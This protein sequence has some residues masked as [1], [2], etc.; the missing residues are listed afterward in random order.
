VQHLLCEV[1]MSHKEKSFT[2]MQGEGRQF[3]VVMLC[4]ETLH[5]KMAK[6]VVPRNWITMCNECYTT[7]NSS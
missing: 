5:V 7:V 6:T 1:N 2:T 3:T 4:L